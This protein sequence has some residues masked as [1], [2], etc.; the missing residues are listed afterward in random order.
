MKPV[1]RIKVINMLDSWSDLT[2]KYNCTT[3]N[4]VVAWSMNQPGMSH[5]LC[6]ARKPE[7][8]LET[9]AS[10]NVA[11][12]ADELKRMRDDVIALGDPE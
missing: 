9:A 7:H 11:L 12:T 6:G 2:K 8:I 4:L 3:A 1:N 10:A 5:I